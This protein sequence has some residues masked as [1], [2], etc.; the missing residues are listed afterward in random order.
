MES[1]TKRKRPRVDSHI[2]NH[3]DKVANTKRVKPLK[4]PKETVVVPAVVTH[5][6]PNHSEKKVSENLSS[7]KCMKKKKHKKHKSKR[8]DY[9]G[10]TCAAINMDQSSSTPVTKP[11]VKL[12]FVGE[13]SKSA[14][15]SLKSRCND[16][17]HNSTSLS[18]A[19]SN[20]CEASSLNSCL[21][22]KS[23]KRK[24]HIA[25]VD[26]SLKPKECRTINSKSDQV[27]AVGDKCSASSV[28]CNFNIVKLK[29]A[30]QKYGRFSDADAP[31]DNVCDQAS[32][33]D[34]TLQI[35]QETASASAKRNKVDSKISETSNSSLPSVTVSPGGSSRSLKERMM[36]R[37]TSARFRFINE[38]M[39]HST[40]SEAADMFACDKDAFTVY[41]AGFQS[42]VS[43]WPT[44]PVDKMID[45]ISSR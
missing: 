19:S 22:S 17:T 2:K 42:Q 28:V 39:Y 33:K 1:D 16:S 9:D 36:N 40:G 15:E 25:E 10:G 3:S 13:C 18:V 43:K 27:C 7:A 32:Y 31:Q 11:D 26:S 4:V 30:L 21:H 6:H 41:H 38:Q 37:L 34:R 12:K 14:E 29:S 8:S 45:Y 24:R 5:G 35:N 23:R 20:V 44:N